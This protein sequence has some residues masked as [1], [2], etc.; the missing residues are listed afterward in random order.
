MRI[1]IVGTGS[2]IF[3]TVLIGKLTELNHKVDLLDVSSYSFINYADKVH[4]TIFN[5]PRFLS[6]LLPL[7]FILRIW[8][9]YK[10]LGELKGKYDVCQILYLKYEY[11]FLIESII[12]TSDK[13]VA[14]VYGF[15][16]VRKWIKRLFKRVYDKVD[17][18]MF[19][20]RSLVS[21][22]LA[23]FGNKY[24][25]KVKVCP[26]VLKSF[27]SISKVKN[28]ETVDQSREKL[29]IEKNLVAV[30]CGGNA[31]AN[32][33][34]KK[35]IKAI[36]K[37]DYD[38]EKVLFIFPLTYGDNSY[39][40]KIIKFIKEQLLHHKV[41]ILEEF[42]TEDD[43]ARLRSITDIY[44]NI[45]KMD[46][47][48]GAMLESLYAGSVVITGGWLKYQVLCDKGVFLYKVDDIGAVAQLIADC[49]EDL[50][51]QKSLCAVNTRIIG[52]MYNRKDL[53]NRWIDVY[54][55]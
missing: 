51:T 40:S 4:K 53:I 27:D 29:G 42:M 22:F 54:N 7:I 34:H 44:I 46:Q 6:R 55:L 2:N 11:L 52:E 10:L 35:L 17:Y 30:V 41:K 3:T 28:Q 50:Q 45:Q 12:L 32:Q 16:F 5:V 38:N 39:K 18:I 21:E 26:H 15:S 1:L 13:T 48:S 8:A 19:A 37:I 47:L 14:Y 31:I 25:E 9:G 33:Q 24:E 20:N 23:C 49:V 43:V 36:H